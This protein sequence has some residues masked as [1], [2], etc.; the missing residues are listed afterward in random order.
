MQYW[1]RNNRYDQ[2]SPLTS[3]YKNF[4]WRD[5]NG[6]GHQPYHQPN[7]PSRDPSKEEILKKVGKLATKYLVS[8]GLLSPS[9]LERKHER[10]GKRF[11]GDDGGARRVYHR[12]GFD[13]G[14]DDYKDR[15]QQQGLRDDG[16]DED[17]N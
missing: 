3:S 6:F 14:G 2:R 8:K 9:V 10:T 11:D 13:D 12:W 4:G 7:P 16:I 5:G 15:W 17:E 1:H